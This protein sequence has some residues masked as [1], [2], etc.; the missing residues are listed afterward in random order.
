MKVIKVPRPQQSALDPNRP[1][2][3]LLQAQIEHLQHAE[4]RLPLRYRSDIYTHSIRT[5]GEAA[6]YIRDVTEAIHK[7]HQDAQVQRAKQARRRRK[8][9]DIAA[10]A[11]SPSRKRSS[12]T[13]AKKSAG[14]RGKKRS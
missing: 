13:K 10:A 5:E 1:A 7:A 2:N 3:A 6:D 9:L 14:N 12:R 11:E 4:R 8:G